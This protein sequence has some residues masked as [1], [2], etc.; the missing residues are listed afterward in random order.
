MNDRPHFVS[1]I[2]NNCINTF[3]IATEHIINISIIIMLF[4]ALLLL[5]I[6]Y[7]DWQSSWSVVI[8]GVVSGFIASVLIQSSIDLRECRKDTFKLHSLW[9]EFYYTDYGSPVF[10]S[11]DKNDKNEDIVNHVNCKYKIISEI[12]NLLSNKYSFEI[13]EC[14]V[15]K[16]VN[17]FIMKMEN[18]LG[19]YRNDQNGVLY[20]YSVF[21][22]LVLDTY[23]SN[24]KTYS[25]I[26]AIGNIIWASMNTHTLIL[27]KYFIYKKSGIQS[28]NDF[29]TV[30][31][32]MEHMNENILCDMYKA[33]ARALHRNLDMINSELSKIWNTS[34]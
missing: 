24:D 13:F 8:V 19:P 2:A 20:A 34:E 21:S 26:S 22:G 31:K 28:M 25:Y 23:E 18:M 7:T 9:N 27:R 17:K 30:I 5:S 1:K 16:T 3:W 6:K 29:N 4:V 32:Y 10:R 33:E 14:N 11:N 12:N 15:D